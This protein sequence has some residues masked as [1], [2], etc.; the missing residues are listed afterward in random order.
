MYVP[1]L[2]L[3]ICHWTIRLFQVMATVNSAATSMYYVWHIKMKGK[4]Y[5]IENKIALKH[6]FPLFIEVRE[7]ILEKKKIWRLIYAYLI[8]LQELAVILKNW[9]DISSPQMS[10]QGPEHLFFNELENAETS[11][12][13]A[14]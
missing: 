5:N 4:S 13:E 3:F 1:H 12:L 9:K 14:C 8:K 2:Y 11:L 6:T 7:A 10:D